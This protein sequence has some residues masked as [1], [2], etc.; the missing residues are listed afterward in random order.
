MGTEAI[1]SFQHQGPV[2]SCTVQPF[3]GT[4]DGQ[5]VATASWDGSVCIFDPANSEVLKRLGYGSSENG[6]KMAGLYSVSFAKLQQDIIGCTS[7]DNCVYLWDFN[8]GEQLK[9]LSGHRDEV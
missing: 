1:P 6:Q 2:H 5:L 4:K 8:S 9:A 7:C 3:I